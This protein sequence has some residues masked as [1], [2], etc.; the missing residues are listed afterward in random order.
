MVND[1]TLSELRKAQG[2]GDAPSGVFDRAEGSRAERLGRTLATAVAAWSACEAARQR[3]PRRATKTWVTGQNPRR[4]HAAMNGDTVAVS[5]K[6]SNG[7]DWPGDSRALD[8][9]D[10]ANCNCTLEITIPD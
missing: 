9:A 10:V 6:F 3:A 8:A 7:A 4:S 5:A 2:E 1:S